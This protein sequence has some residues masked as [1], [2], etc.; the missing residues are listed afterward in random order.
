MNNTQQQ[1]YDR[2]EQLWQRWHSLSFGKSEVARRVFCHTTGTLQGLLLCG[3]DAL[4]VK[5]F[6]EV[7]EAHLVEF[8]RE[9]PSTVQLMT[10]ETPTT[11]LVKT[12]ALTP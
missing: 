6:V 8:E 1:Q 3:R 4:T 5:E 2:L 10:R 12:P 7:F 11:P 9:H